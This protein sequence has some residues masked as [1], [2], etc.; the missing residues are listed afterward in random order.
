MGQSLDGMATE[1]GSLGDTLDASR[2][3]SSATHGVAAVVYLFVRR[4]GRGV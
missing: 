1:L 3:A 2:T 4:L